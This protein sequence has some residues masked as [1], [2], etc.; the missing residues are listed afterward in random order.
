MTMVTARVHPVHLMN[1]DC[2]YLLTAWR[3]FCVFTARRTYASSVLGVVILSVRPSVRLSHV[4]LVTNPK[5]G[6][7]FIPHERA[8]LLVF[9]H[10]TVVGRQRPLPPKW[11]TPFKNRSRRQ[12]SACNVSTVTASEKNSTV[13]NRKSYTGFPTSYRWSTYVTYKSPK[14]WLKKRTFPFFGIKVNLIEWSLL[15]GF[16]DRKLPAAKL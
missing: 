15:Q 4:C 3:Y 8:I 5:I 6:D 9:C 12:I 11:P 10:P 2:F 13:A 14:G 16:F 7:I 1:A